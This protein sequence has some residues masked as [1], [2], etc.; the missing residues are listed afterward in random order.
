MLVVIIDEDQYLLK[1]LEIILGQAGHI[2]ETFHSAEAAVEWFERRPEVD[3]LVVDYQL[4]YTT[5]VELLERLKDRFYCGCRVI[6]VSGYT[7]VVEHLDLGRMGVDAFLP[8]PLD[9]EQ[10]L[11]QTSSRAGVRVSGGR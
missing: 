8:K 5:A 6:L 2:V 9:L 11:V 4:K 3:V 7:E 10:L 1:S